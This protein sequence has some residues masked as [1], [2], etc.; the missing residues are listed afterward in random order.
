MLNIFGKHCSISKT[1]LLYTGTGTRAENYQ[2]V[3]I[4]DA[5]FEFGKVAH[6]SPA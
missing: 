6:V 1:I 2:P 3:A 4:S 5:D